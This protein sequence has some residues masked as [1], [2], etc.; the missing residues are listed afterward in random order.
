MRPTSDRAREAVFNILSSKL[1]G[2]WAACDM[3][4]VFAGT[5]AVGLEALS[6]GVRSV[7]LLDVNLQTAHRNAALLPKKKTVSA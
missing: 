7:T 5:G 3:L 4:D 6:R 2:D 1:A